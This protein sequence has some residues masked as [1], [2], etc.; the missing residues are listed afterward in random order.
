MSGN[1]A[2]LTSMYNA[3]TI[4]PLTTWGD[5]DCTPHY[6]GSRD[7]PRRVYVEALLERAKA[8]H[9]LRPWVNVPGCPST[10]YCHYVIL[11]QAQG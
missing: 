8:S 9:R 1:W 4:Y 5:T 10:T 7:V 11:L 6:I 3:E 2:T